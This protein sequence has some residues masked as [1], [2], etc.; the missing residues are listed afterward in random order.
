[1]LERQN[2]IDKLE[3]HAKK[4]MSNLLM[5]KKNLKIIYN[6]NVKTD[7]SKELLSRQDHDIFRHQTS[8]GPHRDDLQFLSMRLMLLILVV[9]D[10]NEPLLSQ[11]N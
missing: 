3:V 5:V 7:F 4:S 9:K 11:L 10:N 2:F 8:V 1:M 6:Q